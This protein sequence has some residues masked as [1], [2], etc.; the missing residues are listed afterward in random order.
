[1]N[2][3]YWEEE[4]ETMPREELHKLQLRRLR[5]TIG[6]AANSPYYNKFSK[7]RHYGRQ[8][9][10]DRR[11]PENPVYHQSGH[12]RQLPLRTCGR[13]YAR[14]RCTHPL[15][16]RNHGNAHRHRPL[17]ARSGVLGQPCSTLPIRSRHTKDRCFFKTVPAMACSPED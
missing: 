4:I 16:Q 7:A 1:M 12:A 6:I 10:V 13:Q 14:R 11:H 17:P 15:F 3:K 5:K 2:D 9:P 8:H